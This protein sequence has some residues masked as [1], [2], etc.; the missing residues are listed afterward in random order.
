MDDVVNIVDDVINVMNNVVDTY[1]VV[2]NRLLDIFNVLDCVVKGTGV[3][4]LAGDF[5][6]PFSYFSS[7]HTDF[8]HI[9]VAMC[10][11]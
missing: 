10:Y 8:P 6:L 7:D 2:V 5:K 1:H 3:M 11:S 4:K 9:R